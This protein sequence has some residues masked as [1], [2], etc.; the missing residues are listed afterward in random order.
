ML[1]RRSIFAAA[2]AS[3]LLL[4]GC[5]DP[6][7][8]GSPSRA[9]PSAAAEKAGPIFLL[10]STDVYGDIASQIGGEQVEVTSI[11]S[12]EAQDPH[13]YEATPRDE[14]AVS[15]ADVV[16][17]NGGGYD[18][19]MT[20]L[21]AAAEGDRAVLS[22]FDLAR[23]NGE[24]ASAG[25]G[26]PGSPQSTDSPDSTP[27][28]GSA[29]T[30]GAGAAGTSDEQSSVMNEHLWYDLDVMDAVSEKLVGVLSEIAPASRATFEQNYAAFTRA[31]D[32]LEAKQAEIRAAHGGAD[33]AVTEIVADW[34]LQDC[35]LANATP[36]EFS[37]AIEEGTDVPTRVLKETLDLLTDG[38]VELLVYNEQTTGP[39]TDQLREAANAA[40]LPIVAVRETL[41]G[42]ADYLAW[43]DSTLDALQRALA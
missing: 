38:S 1:R 13:S 36:P 22:A 34:L 27:G 30:P 7:P 42:G 35:G 10:A 28:A 16:V 8:V 40:G 9:D 19:F 12:G 32:G 37:E 25:E 11:I 23:A 3:C 18:E 43:M 6:D 4:M 21:L 33:V 2:L 29:S 41:P 5:G 17:M 14:L 15:R 31:I 20:R 39:Q 24:E 26:Q